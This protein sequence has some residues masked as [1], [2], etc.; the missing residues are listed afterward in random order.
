MHKNRYQKLTAPGFSLL[1]M[2]IV[3]A[4]VGLLLAGL[5]PTIA[6]QMDQQHRNDTRKLMEEAKEA[7][8]GFSMSNGY[9]PCP[10]SQVG[11][12]EDRNDTTLACN[13]RMGFLPWAT[14]GVNQVDGWGHLLTYSASPDYTTAS[15]VFAIIGS[16]RD[17]SIR[18]LADATISKQSDVPAVLI[19]HGANGLFAT[20]ENGNII[21]STA[22]LSFENVSRQATNANGVGTAIYSADPTARTAAN[23][24]EFDDLVVWIS[25]N[26]LINRMVAAGRLP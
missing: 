19:S 16:T 24:E 23:D 6:A 2:A 3:L 15:Q 7:L 22:P 20:L 4:I 18:N 13:R 11:G 12:L 8:F 5:L 10:A 9:L 25:P 21:N 14:L 1:E 26:V 17:I